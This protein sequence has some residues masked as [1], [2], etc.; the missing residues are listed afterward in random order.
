MIAAEKN[1]KK[2]SWIRKATYVIITISIISIA[3]YS[4]LKNVFPKKYSS[5]VDY[6]SLEYDLDK[7]LVYSIIKVESGFKEI[8]ISNKGAVGLMQIMPETG[9]W[10]AQKMGI[11]YYTEDMLVDT[12]V[13][14]KMGCFYLNDLSEEFHGD[15]DLIL[16]AYN[17]GRG[18]VKS[19]LSDPQYSDDG[20]SLTNIPFKETRNYLIKVKTIYNIYKFL[21]GNT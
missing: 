3:S 10:I 2:A 16:A 9:E 8:A 11:D 15:T 7:Y 17:G 14:I 13:N 12:E 21:Y 4:F 1:I 6:F 20:R 5:Y 18:N 19:W